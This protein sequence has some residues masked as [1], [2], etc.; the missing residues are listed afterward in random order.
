MFKVRHKETGAIRTVY[1]VSG[2]MF[3]FYSC[4]EWYWDCLSYYEPVEVVSDGSYKSA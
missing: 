2:G 4:G 1:K 3:M